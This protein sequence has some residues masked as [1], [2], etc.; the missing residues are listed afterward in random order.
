[1]LAI[2]NKVIEEIELLPAEKLFEIYDL[3][4]FFRLGL[5][6]NKKTNKTIIDFAGSWSGMSEKE[7]NEFSDDIAMRRNNAFNLRRDFETSID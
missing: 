4:H 5:Q 7:F 1:M 6:T 2:R 3:I